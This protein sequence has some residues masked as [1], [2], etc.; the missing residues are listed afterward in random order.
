MNTETA[1]L[2][3]RVLSAFARE[4]ARLSMPGVT[5]RRV[6]RPRSGGGVDAFLT[7][8]VTAEI[9]REDAAIVLT[10]LRR[11]LTAVGLEYSTTGGR[12]ETR[13]WIPREEAV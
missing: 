10:D 7:M 11:A 9:A 3:D 1:A 5:F 6:L 8:N 13:A 2:R 12:Y 4:S